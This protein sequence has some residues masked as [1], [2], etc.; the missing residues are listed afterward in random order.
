MT[1]TLRDTLSAEHAELDQLA[2]TL[3]TMVSEPRPPAAFSATRWRLNHVL[4]VH[5]AKEDQHLYPTLQQSDNAGTRALA[6]RFAHEMGG[7]AAAHQAYCATWP[8]EAVEAD[9]TGFRRETRLV[10]TLLRQRIQREETQLSTRLDL[11]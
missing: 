4:T 1:M 8:I 2:E 5:L 9:W 7:L 11:H 6:D 3:L 10:M